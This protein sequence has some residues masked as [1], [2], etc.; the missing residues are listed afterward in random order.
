MP[1][2]ATAEAIYDLLV[3]DDVISEGLGVYTFANGDTLPAIGCYLAS[4]QLPPGTL[5]D[6]IE[7][8]ITR[9]PGYGNQPAYDGALLNPTWRIYVSGFG[10]GSASSQQAM[11][12]RV[13]DLLPG[14]TG[15]PLEGDPPGEGIGVIAQVVVTWTNP[16]VFLSA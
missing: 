14:S 7:I 1:L 15:S 11:A 12:E 16:T 5:V 3:A 4:E 13:M 2:P 6:G 10:V 9:L 8:A